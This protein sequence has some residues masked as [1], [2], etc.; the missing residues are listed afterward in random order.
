[1]SIVFSNTCERFFIVFYSYEG[2]Q[3]K[4]YFIRLKSF[5]FY[6]NVAWRL[7]FFS[8]LIN[9]NICWY[10]KKIVHN[11]IIIIVCKSHQFDWKSVNM[12][13]VPGFFFW[14]VYSLIEAN[15]TQKQSPKVFVSNQL[16]SILSKVWN[17]AIKMITTTASFIGNG[18]HWLSLS[19]WRF[20]CYCST[21]KAREP[22][23]TALLFHNCLDNKYTR[24]HCKFVL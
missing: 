19:K 12:R 15:D 1:M 20:F 7:V 17:H 11:I 6:G 22:L 8:V 5:T 9:K 16:W 24:F 2:Q 18:F 14:I 13:H 21:L 10:I 23:F 4:K 3:K